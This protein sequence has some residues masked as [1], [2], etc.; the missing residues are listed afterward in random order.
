MSA[1]RSERF[2][3]EG[4]ARLEVQF[5]AGHLEAVEGEPGEV[6]VEVRGPHA[7]SFEIARLGSGTIIVRPTERRMRWGSH[8]VVVR[9]PAGSSLDARVASADVT[10]AVDLA[11][12]VAHSASGDVTAGA[13]AGDCEVNTASGDVRLGP[14]GG[15]LSAR[16]TS[17]DI[18]AAS[19]GGAARLNTASGDLRLDRADADVETRTASGDLEVGRY[20][21]A[22]LQAQ[23][24][25]G[26][27]RIGVPPGR[28]LDVRLR[29]LSG[30]IRTPSAV[31]G[32]GSSTEPDDGRIEVRSVSGDITLVRASS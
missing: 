22:D 10:V 29:S 2:A 28:D 16:S 20:A 8:R 24:M 7:D 9:A 19:V 27:V 12:V 3:V 31:S 26:N 18:R 15:T 6:T 23:T 13:I 4:P 30:S 25:S 32:D 11:D 1:T 14:V 5:P 21:G 17:G